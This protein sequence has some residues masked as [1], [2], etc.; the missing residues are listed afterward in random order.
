VSLLAEVGV[1]V[2]VIGMTDFAYAAGSFAAPVLFIPQSTPPPGALV[3]CGKYAVPNNDTFVVYPSDGEVSA[4][5]TITI[6]CTPTTRLVGNGTATP[7]CQNDGSYSQGRYCSACQTGSAVQNGGCSPCGLGSFEVNAKCTACPPDTYMDS[8]GRT[9]C[10]ACPANTGTTRKLGSRSRASCVCVSG[11]V[12]VGEA[13]CAQCAVGKYSDFSGATTCKSCMPF[14]NTSSEGSDRASLC[15]C[16]PGYH[17]K[18][19]S[20]EMCLSGTFKRVLGNEPCQQCPERTSGSGNA[21]SS[22]EDCRC[23][24]GYQ[25][26]RSASTY[27]CIA[28][29]AGK[30]KPSSKEHECSDCGWGTVSAAGQTSCDLCP[31]GMYSLNGSTSC[32]RCTNGKF[33]ASPGS[34]CSVCTPGSFLL[35]LGSACTQCSVG[36]ESLSAG[37]SQCSQCPPGM[38]NADPGE[39]CKQCPAGKRSDMI[40]KST[41][42]VD[43]TPGKYS[44]S[45]GKH[46]CVQCGAGTYASGGQSGCLHC[47]VGT[48]SPQQSSACEKCPA[49]QFN[50]KAVQSSCR[51]CTFAKY[52]HFT[53]MSTCFSCPPNSN[54]TALG[55]D[56]L[57]DC[58]CTGGEPGTHY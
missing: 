12:R 1:N 54:T 34:S 51:H 16:N 10:T 33:V 23:I 8:V 44:S 52:M 47:N 53:G 28:C 4:G 24:G 3:K 32:S 39:V 31:H 14:T 46:E 45:A 26:D 2:T 38:Y 43:C 57:A 35:G 37:A 22:V 36:Q 55:A 20:C 17:K 11:Y 27:Q 19:E 40:Y 48:Y 15:M 9:A 29:A 58:I 41:L 50:D 7:L 25:A 13:S 49:G 56:A 21:S 5:D 18:D 30:Y 6:A 42:C